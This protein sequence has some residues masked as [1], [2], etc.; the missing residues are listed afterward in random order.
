MENSQKFPVLILAFN[1]PHL[2]KELLTSL[3]IDFISK[4]YISIDGPRNQI[5]IEKANII[6]EASSQFAKFI[7]INIRRCDQNLGCRLGVISGIDWFFSQELNGGV[8][9]ED[10]CFPN[11][12][13]FQ[14]LIKTTNVQNKNRF[15]MVTAHNPLGKIRL[16]NFKSKF[17]FISGWY[18]QSETWKILRETIFKISRPSRF[19]NTQ[20]PRTYYEAIFWWAAYMR[21]RIGIHDT[22]DSLLYRSFSENGYSCLVP[23]EN[24]IENHG[25]GPDATHTKDPDGS[26]MLKDGESFGGNLVTEEELDQLLLSQYFKI[27]RRHAITPFFRVFLDFIKIRKFPDFEKQLAESKSEIIRFTTTKR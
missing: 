13:F 25:F 23:E 12:N 27:S 6:V 4:I 26:I 17:I 22:W 11:K 7:E 24:L 21:A 2:I 20:F 18:M 3:P 9:L 16:Q 15:A 8:I 5:D 1:R 10:D 14:Y 19:Q